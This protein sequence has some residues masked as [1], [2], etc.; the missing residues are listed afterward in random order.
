VVYD[1][2]YISPKTIAQNKKKNKARNSGYFMGML[3]QGCNGLDICYDLR[4]ISAGFP[5]T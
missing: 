4:A 2:I 3:E 5:T 1:D